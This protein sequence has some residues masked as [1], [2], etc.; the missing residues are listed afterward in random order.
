MLNPDLAIWLMFAASVVIGY[1][2]MPIM[3]GYDS[4]Y[5]RFHGN[6]VV[7]SF[8]M[9][10]L[11]ALVEVAM[12]SSMMSKLKIILY[13]LGFG[14]ISL[15]LIWMMQT[16]WFITIDGFLDG[17]I[18]HHAMALVMVKPFLEGKFASTNIMDPRIQDVRNLA[19]GIY[20]TQK[21]EIMIMNRL[22]G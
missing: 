8:L 19:K 6:K 3:L 9:G 14:I 7:S 13:L 18:E 21:K 5:V 20:E 22:L 15:V 12:H 16:Q 1:V 2:T 4:P 10:C 17:M 11:M